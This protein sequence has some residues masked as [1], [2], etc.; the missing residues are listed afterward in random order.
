MTDHPIPEHVSEQ[1]GTSRYVL[2]NEPTRR[3]TADVS[4]WGIMLTTDRDMDTKHPIRQAVFLD[5]S[6]NELIKRII[7]R[8]GPHQ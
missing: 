2:T 3:V 6:E 5:W 7:T 1:S 8:H 4:Q